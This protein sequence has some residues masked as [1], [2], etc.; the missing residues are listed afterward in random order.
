M[1]PILAEPVVLETAGEERLIASLLPSVPVDA[2]GTTTD[3][4]FSLDHRLRASLDLRHGGWRLGT[5]WDL[6][7]GQLGGQTW[8][9]EG[10]LD[11]RHREDRSL[12]ASDSFRPRRAAIEGRLGPVQIAAGLMTSHWGLGMVAN[13]GAHDPTF[14]RS[15]FGDRVV[16]LRLSTRPRGSDVPWM[17][18]LMGDRVLADDT[19]RLDAGQDA[20]QGIAATML[21]NAETPMRAGLYGVV[22]HQTEP[23]GSVTT[24]TVIDLYTEG[25]RAVSDDWTLSGGFEGAGISGFTERSRSVTSVEGLNVKSAGLTGYLALT[26]LDD[27]L[28]LKVRGGWAS[29]DA[30][31]DDDTSRDFSFDRDYDAGMVIFDEVQGAINA[32]SYNLLADLEHTGHVADGADALVD[33]GAV[34]RASFVQPLID[35]Q[36]KDW[37]GLRVGA[38]LAW[39]TAPVAHPYYTYRAGGTPTN[40]LNQTT[41]GYKLGTELDWALHLSLPGD[42]VVA[43]DL[44]VQGGHLLPSANLGIDTMASLVMV[45]GRVRW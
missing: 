4:G 28:T 22:R 37:L 23:D 38:T 5:E 45:Q 36:P 35:G 11:E 9:L 1:V 25:K 7:T 32:Q 2:L 17:V 21:G 33:E 30:D 6:L 34:K 10:E 31:P 43:P 18:A 8:A 15:D 14:G 29:G 26:G 3:Q 39:A 40:Q 16:R 19:A 24:A 27:G 42:R 41:D 20:W 12:F 13:D 44:L